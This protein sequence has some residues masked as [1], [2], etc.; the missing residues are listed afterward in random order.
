MFHMWKEGWL[1][2]TAFVQRA[3]LITG[4]MMDIQEKADLE[5]VWLRCF[6]D[7]EK[8]KA[9]AERIALTM[10]KLYADNECLKAE[11][12]K[13]YAVYLAAEEYDKLS[14]RSVEGNKLKKAVAAVKEQ[15]LEKGQAQL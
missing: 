11:R 5:L 9:M 6:D 14:R 12:E 1:V 8:D 4:G 2:W 15:P 7:D 13:L 3:R 10:E